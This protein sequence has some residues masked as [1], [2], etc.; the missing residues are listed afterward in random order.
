[1]YYQDYDYDLA[2]EYYTRAYKVNPDSLSV[3]LCMA[4]TNHAIENYGSAKRYY[5]RLKAKSPEFAKQFAYLELKAEETGRAAEA[6]KAREVL[7][8]EE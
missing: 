6:D 5:Q 8:W 2:L 7:L 4:R 1:M 3:L